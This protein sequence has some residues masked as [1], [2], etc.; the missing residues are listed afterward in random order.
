MRYEI[1]PVNF[2]I[3]IFE[4][5][6]DVPFQYQPDYPN[7]DKFDTYEE[8]EAWAQ[9]SIAAHALDATHYAPNGKG[10]APEPIVPSAIASGKA[11]LEALGL[12]PEEITALTR[13]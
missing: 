13:F 10:L 8:A 9:A 2:A 6:S 4:N 11:K 5:G 3:S 7:L 12:T 1:D